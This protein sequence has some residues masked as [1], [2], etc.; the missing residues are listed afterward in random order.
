MTDT[1]IIIN[2]ILMLIIILYE[3]YVLL[4][5]KKRMEHFINEET[6]QNKNINDVID[7]AI[8]L[9]HRIIQLESQNKKWRYKKN[10]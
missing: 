7:Y 9:E 6:M 1:I 10:D 8:E 3:L 5:G 4:T 2:T